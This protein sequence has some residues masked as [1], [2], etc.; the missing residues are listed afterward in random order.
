MRQKM[1]RIGFG[2]R[3]TAAAAMTVVGLAAGS[4]SANV[5][6]LN[7]TFAD[8]SRTETNL[9]NE[10]AVYASHPDAV[11]MGPGSLS[12]S[13][14]TSSQ[15]LH[16]YFAP[17]GNPVSVGVGEQ[18]LA[19]ID[20]YARDGLG[21]STSRNFRVGLFHDPDGTHVTTDGYNDAGGSGNPWANAEGYSAFFPLSSSPGTTN[22]FQIGKRTVTDGSQTSLMG[23]GA[24]WTQAS[25][26]G[27]VVTA[28]LNNLYTLAIELDR[29]STDQMNVTY[30]LSDASGV[31]ATQTVVDSTDASSHLGIG[32]PYVNFDMLAFRFSAANGTADR[33]EFTRFHVEHIPEPAALSLVGLAGLML[34][35]RRRA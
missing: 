35:R 3:C 27:G 34:G 19:E 8:G 17:V 26:G 22:L 20:F 24:A 7:D 23:A 21:T 16:T 15:R 11:T 13:Q 29:I 18:L 25:A 33:L 4:A 1:M 12:Y 30:T 28:A 31:L 5:V 6:L 10:S 9:P 2:W 14:S 32:A